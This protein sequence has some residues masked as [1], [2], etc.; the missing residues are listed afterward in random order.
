MPDALHTDLDVTAVEEAHLTG[1]HV[2]GANRQSGLTVDERKIDQ[3]RQ[4]LSSGAV[5]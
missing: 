5:E 2:R 1:A 3:F 4:R